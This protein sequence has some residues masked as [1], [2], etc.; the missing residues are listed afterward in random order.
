MLLFEGISGVEKGKKITVFKERLIREYGHLSS[1]PSN[2]LK[3]K[4]LSRVF[5]AIVN[6][7]NLDQI[8]YFISDNIED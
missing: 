3:G 8:E 2:I 7:D 6:P 4:N 1:V 5:W